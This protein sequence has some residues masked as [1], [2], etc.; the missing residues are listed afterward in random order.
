MSLRRRRQFLIAGSALLAAPLVPAQ[1]RPAGTPFRIG[2]FAALDEPFLGW[3][4]KA[5]QTTGWQQG[6][7][8]VFVQS[9]AGYGEPT[10]SA[11]RRLIGR[12][13]DLA[14]VNSTAHAAALHR[15]TAQVPIVMW[16]SGYPVEA[17][18][19][20]SLARPG[21]NVTGVTFYAGTGIWGKLLELLHELKPGI[22]RIG[23]AWGYV[24]PAFPREEVEPCYRE[25]RQA[26]R[27]LKLTLHI[28]EI[29]VPEGVPAGL[30]SLEAAR[31]DAL[32]V[33]AG[34]GFFSQRHRVMQYAVAKRIPTV[35]DYRWPP[36]GEPAPLLTYAPTHAV[37]MRKATS[38]VVRILEG[39]ARPGD[40]PIE[41]PS[42]F[43]LVVNQK[44]AKAIGLPIPPSLLLRADQVIE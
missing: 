42:K 19:A 26:A 24:P 44:T 23:V 11:A 37:N 41:Q 39:G 35:A 7:D 43:E 12:K 22:R 14:L 10:V 6:R 17:G 2:L 38:Y 40:L 36:A 13:I 25:L 3:T 5:F 28:E 16:A 34:P 15:V 21:K 1:N 31:P 33:T 8:Y 4:H 20:L 30:A 27:A 9:D 18:L 32:L 29:A